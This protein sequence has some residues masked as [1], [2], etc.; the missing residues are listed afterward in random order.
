MA[1]F[2]AHAKWNEHKGTHGGT[3][4]DQ[5]GEELMTEPWY[6]RG[7]NGVIWDAVYRPKQSN[8]AERI[9]AFAEQACNNN[10]IGYNQDARYTLYEIV[11]NNGYDASA[12]DMDCDCDCSSLVACC[13][14]SAGLAVSASMTT[15]DED[16]ILLKTNMF[17]KYTDDAY[18][19]HGDL[20]RRGDILHRSSHTAIVIQNSDS[21]AIP[22]A[23]PKGFP[24]WMY[25]SVFESGYRYDN[26]D[27]WSVIGGVGNGAYGR[28]QFHYEFGLVPFM[29]Y[30]VNH[31]SS[32]YSAFQPY[33]ALGAGN[34]QLANNTEL[35]NL[36]IQFTQD[37]TE[38]FAECQNTCML[39]QYYRP[40]LATIERKYGFNPESKGAYLRGAICSM[41]IRFGA[42]SA[43]DFYSGVRDMDERSAIIYA[44]AQANNLSQQKYGG[45][46]GRWTSGGQYSEYDTILAQLS[47]GSFVYNLISGY[48][49][50]PG[51]PETPVTPVPSPT[52]TPEPDASPGAS[53]GNGR[54]GMYILQYFCPGIVPYTGNIKF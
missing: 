20:L 26:P 38:D 18:I 54:M 44:Y 13:C 1:T 12:V 52:P 15:R 5:T 41:S 10:H 16:E 22:D 37:Y 42:E 50:P 14:L 35:H 32:K 28:Y 47:E 17:D 9:A 11:K 51:N 6:L 36:F 23:Q 40:C 46:D 3:P 4:G 53:T 33:I 7:G 30:C 43:A 39:E 31:D 45:D 21:T 27:G 48:L 8:V 25:W 49:P 34:P 24:V 19:Y 29:Q 2:I